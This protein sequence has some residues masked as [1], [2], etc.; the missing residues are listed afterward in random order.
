ML[1]LV[2]L[3]I[4]G[5]L[6]LGVA[7]SAC[8]GG[9]SDSERVHDAVRAFG[10]ATAAKDYERL[11][12]RLLAPELVKEVESAGLPCELALRRGL[13]DVRSPKLT[14]G[15]IEVRGDRATADVR[16]SAAGEQPSRDTLQL[17]RT[18]GTS[19]RIASLR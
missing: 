13:G 6:A 11:C 4:A 1:R 5:V 12:D 17:V 9:P 10:E 19:W 3:P 18:G 14:I 15:R 8:G 2:R 16:S 7:L